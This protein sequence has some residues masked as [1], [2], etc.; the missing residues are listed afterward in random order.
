LDVYIVNVHPSKIDVYNIPKNYDEVKDRNNDILYGDRTY[1]DQYSA[2]LITDYIDLIKRLKDLAI[3]Y[4]KEDNDRN[5]FQ[6]EFESLKAKEAK[7]TSD[8][9]GEHREYKDLIKGR[10]E[11]IKVKRIERQYDPNTSTS[12]KDRDITPETIDKLI[13]E[14]EKDTE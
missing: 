8:T 5:A 4:I 13:K 10:F 14:G 2:S 12:F 6:K 9:V 3:N 11:L 7:S 1:N